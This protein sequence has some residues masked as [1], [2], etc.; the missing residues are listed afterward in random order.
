MNRV[1]HAAI[2]RV[3]AL[4]PCIFDQTGNAAPPSKTVYSRVLS[5]LQQPGTG[6]SCLPEPNTCLSAAVTG[7]AAAA[8]HWQYLVAGAQHPTVSNNA[9]A[10]DM[11][12]AGKL[13]EPGGPAAGHCQ[14]LR[15]EGQAVRAVLRLAA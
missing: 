13:T 4:C 14:G 5:L 6:C 12:T 3:P 9:Q 15:P 10:A 11:D 1:H 7:N 2:T 8:I